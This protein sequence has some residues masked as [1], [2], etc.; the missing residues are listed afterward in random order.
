MNFSTE[1][2]VRVIGGK[3]LQ[4]EALQAQLQQFQQ[5]I[6]SQQ[7]EIESLQTKEE[8]GSEDVLSPEPTE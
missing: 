5:I 8:G 3:Q 2:L 4:I 1:D 6:V 7:E